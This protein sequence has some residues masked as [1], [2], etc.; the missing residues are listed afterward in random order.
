MVGLFHVSRKT[1]ERICDVLD[2]EFGGKITGGLIGRFSPFDLGRLNDHDTKSKFNEEL[3]LVKG[4]ISD[5]NNVRSRF[6]DRGD[7]IEQDQLI[8]ISSRL[9]DN[10]RRRDGS[11]SPVNSQELIWSAIVKTSVLPMML[12]QIDFFIKELGV[13][14]GHLETQEEAFWNLKNRAPDYY[15]RTIALRFAEYYV[16][17]TQEK[18]T[19]GTASA[20]GHPSTNFGR[21]LEKIFEVLDIKTR[22][23]GPATYAIAELPEEDLK[24]KFFGHR[25]HYLGSVEAPL[26]A[27]DQYHRTIIQE[28][29]K[30]PKEPPS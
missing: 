12:F 9:D 24:P 28:L 10:A 4:A 23:K 21:A 20:G 7:K 22:V 1:H 16:Q 8:D 6:I 19:F 15:P 25:N 3:K 5:L 2:E 30:V 26:R 17:R 27:N 14:L 29:L 11:K 13:R 18:P